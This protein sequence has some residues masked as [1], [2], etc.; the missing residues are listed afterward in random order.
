MLTQLINAGIF[1]SMVINNEQNKY[2][3]RE[4]KNKINL[5]QKNP[6][7]NSEREKQTNK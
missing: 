7:N 3:K 4:K 5:L 2:R 1:K 6:K